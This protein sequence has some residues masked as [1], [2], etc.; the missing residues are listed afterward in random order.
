MHR[1][2]SRG[3]MAL[4]RDAL[5]RLPGEG[6]WRHV[7]LADGNIGIGGDPVRLLSRVADLLEPGG[8][9]LA[10]LSSNGGLWRGGA[11]LESPDSVSPWFPWAQVDLRSIPTIAAA[12]GFTVRSVRRGLRAFAE[13]QLPSDR[14][15]PRDRLVPWSDP[16]D[17]KW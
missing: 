3:G 13:L 14:I 8:T 7:L 9:A 16:A 6:R 15:S 5:T 11:R 2:L 12:A 4:H 10:E 17:R 1:T